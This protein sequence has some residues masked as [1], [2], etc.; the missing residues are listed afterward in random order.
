MNFDIC[1]A[2]KNR[3]VIQ[4][5]YDGGTRIVEP[6]CFGENSKGNLVLRGF[7]I[8]GYSSSGQSEA[9]KLFKVS[10]MSN[11]SLEGHN[12]NQIRPFYNPNDKGMIRIICNV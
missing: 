2:I 4:F 3:Q 12:F 10:D 9:W 8:G 11:I 1:D 7:Q 6:F 5:Y